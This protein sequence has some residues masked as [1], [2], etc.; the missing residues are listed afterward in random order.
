MKDDGG[1]IYNCLAISS[2]FLYTLVAD[3]DLSALVRLAWFLVEI[4]FD[5]H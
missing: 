2:K 4:E 3:R 1:G 5:S